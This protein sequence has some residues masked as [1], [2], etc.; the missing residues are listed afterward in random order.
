MTRVRPRGEDVRRYII[1]HVE[2]FPGSISRKTADHFNITR[3]A[4]N[5]HLKLLVAEKMLV[6]SGNTRNR[7][8]KL[9]PLLNWTDTVQISEDLAEDVIWTDKIKEV[10]GQLPENS[11]GIWHYAFT[12]MFNNAKDHS[13]GTQIYME[14]NKTAA[15][16]EMLIYDDG[17]GIFRK[18]RQAM[19]LLDDRHAVLELAKGKFT[20]DPNNHTG[21]GIFFSSRMFNDFCIVS[22]GVAFS[23]KKGNPEDWISELDKSRPGT[24]VFMKLHNHTSHTVRKVF[25]QFTSDDEE[26]KFNKTIVPVKLAKYGDDNLISRSQAKR[27]LARVELFKIVLLDFSDVPSIG[28]AFADE[29][30]RVFVNQHPDTEIIPI[31]ENSEIKRMINR[32]TTTTS[33]K[34]PSS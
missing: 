10:L 29:I 26:F 3:Q 22:A 32:V 12:E 28:Q 5:R 17:V 34:T 6:E 1:D 18:I 30:F 25:D 23:H 2:K 9:C 16:V 21:E 7:T 11:M 4:V 15:E 19:N 27:L 8:Y 33:P 13:G 20:T 14:I 24:A 31:H